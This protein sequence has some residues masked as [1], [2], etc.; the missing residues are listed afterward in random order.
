MWLENIN[1]V[2]NAETASGPTPKATPIFAEYRNGMDALQRLQDRKIVALFSEEDEE[3]ITEGLPAQRI[4]GPEIVEAAK[5]GYAYRK[6]DKKDTWTLVKKRPMPHLRVD[7]KHL[8]DPDLQTFVQAF[9]LKPGLSKYD[10][11]ADKADPFLANAPKEGLNYLDLETRSLLQVLFFLS[12]GV[13]VPPEHRGSGIAPMTIDADGREFD[14]QQVLDGL[15]QV[16]HAKGHHRPP[17][18]HVAIRYHDYWFYIDER[19]R[20]SKATFALIVE[21]SRLELQGKSGSS[22]PVLTLPLGGR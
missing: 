13:M 18:A 9:K 7:V 16:C 19:D 20:D 5:A 21:L 11:V 8:D 6:D 4:A 22:A 17:Y 12:H 3:K 10:I 2:S 15:F 1:W 14:W